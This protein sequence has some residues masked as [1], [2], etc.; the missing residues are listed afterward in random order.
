[1]YRKIIDNNHLF[2]IA[3][4]KSTLFPHKDIGGKKQLVIKSSGTQGLV[5]HL[6]I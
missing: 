6:I 1:M 2:P 5:R 4:F 3:F